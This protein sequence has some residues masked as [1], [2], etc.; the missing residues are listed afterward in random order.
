MPL[1]AICRRSLIR[2][3]LQI[4]PTHGLELPAQGASR[5]RVASP[6]E[7]AVLIAALPAGDRPIWATAMYAGLRLGELQALHW[8]DIDFE[9]GIIRVRRSW[10]RYEGEVEPKSKAGTRSVPI[11]A[12]LRRE[13]IRHR[14][15][16]TGTGFAFGR[17]PERPFSHSG[18]VVR[19]YR[20]WREGRLDPIGL[21]ECR[22]TFAS[23]MIAAGVNVKALQ[24]FMGHSSITVTLDLYGHLMPGSEDE[25]A[26]LLDAYMQKALTAGLDAKCGPNA[27]QMKPSPSGLQRS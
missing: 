20:L 1:R 27:G 24:V 18:V 13:L 11:A 21:H 17:S 25:A 7:G 19:A 26:A 23:L 6:E 10:D 4:N 5:D 16:S 14:G 15:S 12:I 8:E 9:R 22:H 2:G 3:D